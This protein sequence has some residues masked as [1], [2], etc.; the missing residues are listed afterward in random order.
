MPDAYPEWPKGPQV[1][2]YLADYAKSHGL[3]RLMRFNTAAAAMARRADGK[4]GWTLDLATLEGTKREDFDFV[5]ICTG[6]FNE[7]Q[8]LPLPGED[9]FKAV[10]G[11]IMHS[12]AYND[13]SLAKGRKVVVLGGSKPTSP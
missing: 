3:D 13:A 12:S 7:P 8:T 4:P 6:Q 5:A 2:A 11:R 9:A 10:G 1:H